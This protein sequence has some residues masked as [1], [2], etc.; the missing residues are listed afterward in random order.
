MKILVLSDSHANLR[1]MRDCIKT[2]RPDRVIHLGDFYDDGAAIAEENP[3]LIVCQVPGNWDRDRCPLSAA[4]VLNYSIGGVRFFMAHGH[5]YRVESGIGAFLADARRANAGIALY[6]HTHRAD[7]HQE[8]DG[9]YV[10]N[11]GSCGASNGSAGVIRID[12][13]AI[14]ACYIIRQ[15]DL[16]EM[17]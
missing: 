11:P 16:E 4:E 17:Q 13:G 8:P 6:G 10:M 5:R 3:H 12:Q 9:M 7:C 1:F 14:T 15:A 2:V